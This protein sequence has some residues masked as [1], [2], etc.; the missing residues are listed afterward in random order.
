MLEKIAVAV[1][2]TVIVA[3]VVMYGGAIVYGL[4]SIR[5]NKKANERVA[6]K[7]AA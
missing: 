2:G 5:E 3:G 1:A 6:R 4:W 7:N